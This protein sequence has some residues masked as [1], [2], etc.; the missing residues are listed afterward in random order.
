MNN[1][2][3][4]DQSES[5]PNPLLQAMR[6]HPLVA[7]F[8][9]AYAFSW[10]V[11]IPFILSEWS[12]LPGNYQVAFVIKGFGPFAAAFFMSWVLEGK[13][14][15][16]RMRKHIRQWKASWLWYLFVLVGIPLLLIAGILVQPGATANFLG[17]KPLLAVTYLFT[18]IAVFFGGGPLGEE[19][20]WR[21]FALPRLQE[22]YGPLLGTL[23]LGVLWTCW[24]LPD[25][26]TSARGAG[27]G[28]VGQHFCTTSRSSCCW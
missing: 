15:V 25:F 14:G 7:Y 4:P 27:R 19:P 21:G 22:K 24:H 28:Q 20:G 10:I 1:S 13:E 18:Y 6:R 8:F 23:I 17:L 3:A 2:M 11:S 16:K 5:A 9:I 12:L 26:L